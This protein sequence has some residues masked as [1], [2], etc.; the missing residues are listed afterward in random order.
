MSTEWSDL[1]SDLPPMA[2]RLGPFP[3]RAFLEANWSHRSDTEASLH[4]ETSSSGAAAITMS[5]G[6]L[7][8][9][10][11]TDLTDYH[12]PL[13]P[14][15]P[16]ALVAALSRWSNT[17]FR[18]D[19]LP[20]EAVTP[21]LAA[22]AESG[23]ETT[24]SEHTFSAVLTLPETYDAWLSSLGKK[25][26]HE[27]RRKRRKFESEFGAIE[28][29]RHTDDAVGLFCDMHRRSSHDKGQ[30]MTARM[31]D[32]FAE[33]VANAG[34]SIHLLIC[35]GTPMAAAFGFE[36]NDGYYFYNS[37]Y[38]PNAAT[39]SPGA[40]LLS[41]MIEAEIQRG[42]EVFDFLKGDHEYKA[43]HGA[44][45]RRLQMIEGRTP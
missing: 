2:P 22:L 5:R 44:Q 14:S 35:N 38:D 37:A 13:G 33:L 7:R 1:P 42:T 18:L 19:S 43:K 17:P 26:R 15:G 20:Q 11:E 6:V 29:E 25:Q 41:T 21:I 40:V 28:V 3:H 16:L 36:T 45:P 27:V 10:G 30:F 31:Q 8:F 34:A 32:Y 4:I 9:A 24:V 39:A 12:A 23:I